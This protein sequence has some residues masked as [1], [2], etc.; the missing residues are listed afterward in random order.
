MFNESVTHFLDS[1]A[2]GGS[3]N[4]VDDMPMGECSLQDSLDD[5]VFCG[6]LNECRQWYEDNAD[7]AEPHFLYDENDRCWEVGASFEL[8]ECD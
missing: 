4:M 1:L 8:R 6:T 5:E 2:A 3:T 7:F